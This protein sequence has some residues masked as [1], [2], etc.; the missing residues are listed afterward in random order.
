MSVSMR[1]PGNIL[2]SRVLGLGQI[3]QNSLAAY[4]LS[5]SACVILQEYGLVVSDLS[6]YSD[7]QGS[8]L[9]DGIVYLPLTHQNEPWVLAK[10][11]GQA[12][13][14]MRLEGMQFSASG[15]ELLSIVELQPV[16]AYTEAMRTFLRNQFQVELTKVIT[17]TN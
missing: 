5:Y 14:E 8:Q 6:G 1:G 17:G 11:Q 3:G 9:V 2:D 15:R 13:S 16:P 4:G 7:Y 12:R 10:Q